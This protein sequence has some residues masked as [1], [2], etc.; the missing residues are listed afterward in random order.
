MAREA[1]RATE[2]AGYGARLTNNLI[3]GGFGG[4]LYPV[5]PNR[6]TVFERPCYPTPLDLPEPPDLAVVVIP[7]RGVADGRRPISD[8][9]S[10]NSQSS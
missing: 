6:P 9:P 2:R 1:A 3:N 10:P 8:R 4:R 7:A 5:N